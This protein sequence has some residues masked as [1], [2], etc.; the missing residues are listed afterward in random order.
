MQV[1]L[2]EATSHGVADVHA[3][4]DSSPLERPANDVGREMEV[5]LY[6]GAG[7]F[8][9]K[10]SRS[11]QA[12]SAAVRIQ[13]LYGS[14]AMLRR[15]KRRRS[16]RVLISAIFIQK[17]QRKKL[18]FSLTA[19][20]EKLATF[21]A[22]TR[23]QHLANEEA[24]RQ[25]QQRKVEE[26]EAVERRAE[27]LKRRWAALRSCVYD[28]KQRKSSAIKLQCMIR[29]YRARRVIRYSRLTKQ[30]EVREMDKLP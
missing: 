5:L 25:A 21:A 6:G 15:V 9:T 8:A 23:N 16:Q 18:K 24:R 30:R 3:P 19:N 14:F 28:Y 12:E 11:R 27:V 2:D 4:P 7:G 26:K 17:I 22:A 13:C 29:A 1:I 10:L 20:A